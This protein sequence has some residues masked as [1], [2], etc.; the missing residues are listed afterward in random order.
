[1]V[2]TDACKAKNQGGF[3][4]IDIKTQNSTLLIKYLHQ[5]YSKDDLSW[6]HLTWQHFYKCGNP[7]HAK[8]APFGGGI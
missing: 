7:P 1:V 5:F 2:W 8:S 3:G 4:I 6:V